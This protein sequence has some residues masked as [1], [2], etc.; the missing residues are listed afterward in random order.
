MSETRKPSVLKQW[1]KPSIVMHRSGLVNKF[2][3]VHRSL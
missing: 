2:G 3:A 1:V